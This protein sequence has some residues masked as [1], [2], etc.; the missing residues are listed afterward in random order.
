MG[1]KMKDIFNELNHS[2][3]IDFDEVSIMMIKDGKIVASNDEKFIEMIYKKFCK[4]KYK[5]KV[6]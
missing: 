1:L 4:E 5:D 6:A 3:I 2:A